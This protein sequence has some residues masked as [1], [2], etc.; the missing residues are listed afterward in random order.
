MQ[1]SSSVGSWAS[2]HSILAAVWPRETYADPGRKRLHSTR[3][4]RTMQHSVRSVHAASAYMIVHAT[5]CRIRN[6]RGSRR[7]RRRQWF[8]LSVVIS[9][10]KCITRDRWHRL[11]RRLHRCRRRLHRRRRRLRRFLRA[12]IVQLLYHTSYTV[13]RRLHC[14]QQ[15]GGARKSSTGAER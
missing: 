14:V 2:K 8:R 1:R 11:W 4:S 9:G 6:G 5:L 15:C 3:S 7:R 13:E 12:K 10:R